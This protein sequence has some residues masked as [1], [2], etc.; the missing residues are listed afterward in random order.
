MKTFILLFALLIGYS[1]LFYVIYSIYSLFKGRVGK[2]APYMPSVGPSKKKML[3]WAREQLQTATH[4]LTIIDLGSGTGS[5]LIPLARAF[6][7]HHFVG[8]EWDFIPLSIARLKSFH[9][10]NMEWRKQNFMTYSC[11]EADIVFC[12]ILKTMQEL[13]GKKLSEEIK[14]D[15]LV[16]SELYPVNHLKQI[17]AHKPSLGVGIPV[18]KLQK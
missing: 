9:L 4:P 15:C 17:E 10:R 14:P 12:Y 7:Q 8:L 1:A 6:P 5:L 16:I 2:F 11:A 13:I 18:Y 3:D